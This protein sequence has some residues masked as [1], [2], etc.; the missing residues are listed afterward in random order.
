MIDGWIIG[1]TALVYLSLLFGVAYWRDRT[2]RGPVSPRPSLYAFSLAVFCTSWT[3]YGSVGLAAHTGYDFLPVYIGPVIAMVFG[4]PLIIRIIKLCKAQ[5]IS[6]IADFIG[7]RYGKNQYL[8]ALVTVIA[9]AGTVPYIA[10]QL[11]AVSISVTTMVGSGGGAVSAFSFID[12]SLLVASFMALFAVLFGTRHVDA[13]EHQEGLM[14]AVAVESFVKLFAFLTVGIFVVYGFFGGFDGLWLEIKK[15]PDTFDIFTRDI[16]GGRW[17]TIGFLSLVSFIL[18]PR[19]FHMMVVEN[20]SIGELKRAVWLF[21][22]YLVAIN[23]FVVP[24]AMAGLLEFS[25]DVSDADFFV[26]KLPQSAGNSYVSLIAF[27]GGLSAASA[28]VMVACV[29]LAIMVCND[30]IV[31]VL[32]YAG[33]RGDGNGGDQA[34]MSSRLLKIRRFTIV[35]I[36]LLAYGF[37]KFFAGYQQLASIGLLSFAAIVQFAPAF[38]GGLFWR[39]ATALGAFGGITVG[40]LVW[41]YTLLL[42]WF[43]DAGLLDQSLLSEGPF[44]IGLLNPQALFYLHFDPLTHGVL[45]SVGLN[46]MAYIGLSLWRVPQPIERLQA[47]IFIENNMGELPD[48]VRRQWGAQITYDHLKQTVARYLGRERSERSFEKYALGRSV[49]IKGGDAAD[50]HALRFTEHLLA[51]AIGAASS[52][53]V[54]SLL[55]RERNISHQA[56]LKLLDD[57]SEALQYNRDFLQSALDQVGQGLCVFDK[58]MKLVVWNRQFRRLLDL[59]GS[60][61]TIG[62]SLDVIIRH[63]VLRGDFGPGEIEE[64]VDDRIRRF[65]GE[66]TSFQEGFEGGDKI[67]EFRTGAM[68]QG[69]VVAVIVNITERVKATEALALMNVT[70]EKRVEERTSELQDVNLALETARK[71]ADEANIYKTRFLAA[72][73]HDILQPLSAARIYTACLADM[74]RKEANKE[75]IPKI[76]RSLQSVEDILGALLELSRYDT[77]KMVPEIK[78]FYLQ[79]LFDQLALEFEPVAALKGLEFKLVSTSCVVGTDERLMRRILQNLISNAIKYTDN[80]RVLI[81]ARRRGDAV[82]IQVLDSGSGIPDDKREEIFKEFQR[83]AQAEGSNEEGVGLG[84]SIVRRISDLLGHEI[85]FVSRLGRGTCFGVFVPLS[86]DT[87]EPKTAR[88]INRGASDVAG[89]RILCVD[90]EV[91]VLDSMELLLGGWGAIVMRAQ[92]IDEALAQVDDGGDVP[93]LIIADYHLG[94][95]TGI[96]AI[97]AI[98]ALTKAD[99][100]AIIVTGDHSAETQRDVKWRGLD[101]LRKPVKPASLR[102]VI[103]SLRTKK[104]MAE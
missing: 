41:A 88:V 48:P 75:L 18:L 17:L 25:S 16:D 10:L 14:M 104:A 93:D 28:M 58:N 24:I 30:V 83:L 31:P 82:E 35:G 98:R 57:A 52:R 67:L 97:E 94:N 1:G 85:S 47:N 77:G 37:L 53:L 89:W 72:A 44:G 6:S 20:R 92:S 103:A 3:F 43:V 95:G 33:L 61:G 81:G 66:V 71:E 36:L 22:L 55:L 12:V 26:L 51:S 5:N 79:D 2:A 15:R 49:E 60:L 69:G 40:F 27:I 91:S 99:V 62:V 68:P 8:A 39:E 50:I 11:K 54:I 87:P 102:S 42:P 23:I 64:I 84:L 86:N 76:D 19:Q 101:M 7:A 65:S 90:D 4:W 9:V 70:L 80:G 78:A 73:S 100:A 56:A 63:C 13:T 29:A 32:I 74:L 45:W 38:F 96:E 59:P 21:P 34:D 46:L